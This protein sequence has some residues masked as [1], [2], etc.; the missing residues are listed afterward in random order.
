METPKKDRPGY[1]SQAEDKDLDTV[2]EITWRTIREIYPH[3]YA[4]GAVQYFLNH[5][6]EENIRADI[7]AG[8]VWLAREQGICPGTVTM[9][10]N[11]IN[12]LFVLPE[13]Q[14]KGWGSSLM[15]FCEEYIRK[16]HSF[17]TL[18]ASFPAWEMYEKRGYRISEYRKIAC[19]NGDF[20][21]F[22]VMEKQS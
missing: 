16:N 1:I 10:K 21:P 4:P 14:R 7:M 2:K 12:R 19:C 18:S 9:N 15:D 22:A 20:L 11:E 5:H 8:N 3:Y 13:Y 6:R 17:V